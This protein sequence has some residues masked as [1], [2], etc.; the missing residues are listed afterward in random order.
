MS[1]VYHSMFVEN[2]LDNHQRVIRIADCGIGGCLVNVYV[3]R[4]FDNREVIITDVEAYVPGHVWSEA[5]PA[6]VELLSEAQATDFTRHLRAM[7]FTP[8]GVLVHVY[9]TYAYRIGNV[10]TTYLLREELHYLADA[11]LSGTDIIV[12]PPTPPPP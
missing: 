8:T 9:T 11:V 1:M 3:K 12:T 5:L 2:F 10:T 7:E 6:F 4:L